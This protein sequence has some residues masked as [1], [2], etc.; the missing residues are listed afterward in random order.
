MRLGGFID[1]EPSEQT[2]RTHQ[3]HARIRDF[4]R[5]VI[6]F[7]RRQLLAQ[8]KIDERHLNGFFE[9]LPVGHHEVPLTGKDREEHVEEA[10]DGENPHKKEV[11]S[12]A[13]GHMVRCVDRFPEPLRKKADQRDG[14]YSNS[15][16]RMR[17]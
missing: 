15:V 1:S 13:L 14:S 12:Q 2:S 6:L 17:M 5:A 7:L 3:N 9:A 16:Y 4:L 11:V 10:V 8:V